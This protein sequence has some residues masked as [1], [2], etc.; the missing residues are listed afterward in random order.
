MEGAIRAA[1][2]GT[3]LGIRG[4]PR[5]QGQPAT[6]MSSLIAVQINFAI[7]AL[8]WGRLATAS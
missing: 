7:V 6:A 8:L 2:P 1:A 3:S 4:R 5:A